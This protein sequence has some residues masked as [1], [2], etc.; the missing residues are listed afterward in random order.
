LRAGDVVAAAGRSSCFVAGTSPLKEEVSDPALLT[1]P[2][3]TADLV[4]T[5]KSRG[6]QTLLTLAE[7]VEARGIFLVALRRGG[8]ELPFTASTIVERGDVLSVT[9][10]AAEVDRVAD[11][12]GYAIYPSATTD[13]LSVAVAIF[14]GGIIGLPAVIV[15]GVPVSLSVPVG[16][17]LAGLLLGHMGS[18]HPRFGRIPDAS[19]ML[20]ESM[21]L[22][23]FVGCVGLQS[24]PGILTAVLDSGGSLL[25][26]AAL[27]ALVP[28]IVTIL[29]G[30]YLVRMSP[31][32]LLGLCAGAGTSGPTLAALQKAADSK[33]PTLGYGMACA[34]G[35][36]LM[37][38][39]GTLL[40]IMRN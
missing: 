39:W 25:I 38:V 9:G 32:V 4:L 19:A 27:V 36:V 34:A 2:T 8:R 18:V 23:A 22:A 7:H 24:G 17:L 31:G 21:G 1:V 37:A 14:I 35:N 40:V 10:S 26:A 3:V 13:L 16:V 20:L 28:P 29:V 33:V 11:E 12:I 30:Y 6:G 15:G 5:N